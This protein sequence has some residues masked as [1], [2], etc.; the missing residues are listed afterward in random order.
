VA[1]APQA[2]LPG[3]AAGSAEG[4]LRQQV[5]VEL[6]LPVP[7]AV[8][9]LA[10]EIRRRHGPAVAAVVF[11]GSCL[12]KRTTDGVLDFYVV[13]DDYRSAYPGWALALANAI[14]PP[15]VFYLEWPFEGETLRTKYAVI[16]TADLRERASLR[17]LDGRVWARF[18]QPA[19]LA[20]VRDADARREIE[21]AVETACRT[22]VERALAMLPDARLRRGVTGEAIFAAGLHETY[23]AELRSERDAAIRELHAACAERHDAVAR[24]ALEALARRGRVSL[25]ESDEGIAVSL[26]AAELQRARRAWRVRRPIAKALAI[27]GL[28]KAAFTFGDWVPYVLWKTERQTGR[29]IQV[30]ERQRRH[31]LIFGWP[32]IARV[33][34]EGIYR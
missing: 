31:P 4:R 34:R 18:C 32:V 6:A 16:S 12:R 28:L 23:R 24:A 5:A 11:Y 7:R 3:D 17:S 2:S 33:I 19:A 22:F 21:D 8:A 26:P 1:E 14:L 20:F 29:R 15:N 10:E 27:A 13:V 9:A 30:S 25:A